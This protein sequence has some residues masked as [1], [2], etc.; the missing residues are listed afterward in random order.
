M[1]AA[2]AH[3]SC[4]LDGSCCGPWSPCCAEYDPEYKLDV[5]L[6]PASAA[7]LEEVRKLLTKN[8]LP[9]DGVAQFI[10]QFVVARAAGHVV[11]CIGIETYGTSALL[12][13]AAVRDDLKGRGIGR[14]LVNEIIDRAKRDSVATMYLLTTTADSYF[15][16]FGFERIDR[17]DVAEEL[18]ASEELRGACPA[19]ATVMRKRLM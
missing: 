15:T 19:S 8:A 2:R 9:L 13:S 16:T 7:D 12:R 17:A 1:T 6:E 4:E 3:L 14:L 18:N 5:S 10:E 11:G